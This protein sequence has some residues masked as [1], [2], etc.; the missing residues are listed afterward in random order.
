MKNKDWSNVYVLRQEYNKYQRRWFPII[1]Y[2]NTSEGKTWQEALCTEDGSSYY[3]NEVKNYTDV[4]RK[5][6]D[7][8]DPEEVKRIVKEYEHENS[9]PVYEVQKLAAYRPGIA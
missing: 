8:C 5:G 1:V 6:T 9:D 7:K 3:H 2:W 4:T